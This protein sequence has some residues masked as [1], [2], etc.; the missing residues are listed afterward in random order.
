MST[1]LVDRDAKE[2]L[3]G[4]WI[5][6]LS[7]FPHIRRDIERV[8]A[9]FSRQTDRYRRAYGRLNADHP[10]QCVFIASANELEFI[11]MTGNRRI[12][13][14]PLAGLVDLAAIERDR[15]QLWAEAIHRY[16]HCVEW[17]LPPSIEAIAGAMQDAFMEADVWD[18]LILDFL[19]SHYPLDGAQREPFTRRAVV[20]GIGF[21]YQPGDPKFPSRADEQ[22][23]ARRLRRLGYRPDPHR[24]R[25]T[26]RERVWI[27]V[28]TLMR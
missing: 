14:I 5:I 6:E 8:K 25:S 21:S 16:H 7:E 28:K 4:K 13:P 27:S 26:G 11:D 1:N 12:W 3:T 10:R 18:E 23:V 24:S 9:F 20:E 2:S 22:R 15:E 19:E 17:W